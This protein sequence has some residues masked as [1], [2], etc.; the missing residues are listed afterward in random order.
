MSFETEIK[1]K[2]SDI[3]RKKIEAYLATKSQF[4]GFFYQ[5]DHYYDTRP[6]SY[7]ELDKA[8]RIRVQ[9]PSSGDQEIELTFK[10]PKINQ[11][12]K[13]RKEINL[14]FGEKIDFTTIKDFLQE[15]GFFHSISIQKERREYVDINNIHFS[16]DKNILGY[17]LEIEI[18]INKEK[19]IKETESKMWELLCQ[20][21]GELSEKRR[22]TKS[23]LELILESK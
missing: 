9:K 23:Y 3:E 11:N 15:L 13:T 8:L 10:G 7:A 19:Q 1:I 2:L 6:P 18:I 5:E 21:L 16:L 4:L 17:F 22:I 12:S 14:N 20:I